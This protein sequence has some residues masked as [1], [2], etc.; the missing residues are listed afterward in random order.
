MQDKA[1]LMI[2][3]LQQ[4]IGELASDYETK[5]A[6]LRAEITILMNEKDQREK[7]LNEYSKE[8]EE[9]ISSVAQ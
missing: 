3:A 8:I 7:E 9:K 2:T 4:R 5:I 1:E 6:M